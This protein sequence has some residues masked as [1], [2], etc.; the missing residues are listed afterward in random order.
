MFEF[1]FS[2]LVN[3]DPIGAAAHDLFNGHFPRAQD[4][5]TQKRNA[6]GTHHKGG[7]FT[8]FNVERESQNTTKLVTGFG[9]HL[10]IDHTAVALGIESFAEG[11]SG[12]HQDHIS[13]LTDAIEGHPAR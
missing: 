7:Q 6:E 4:A 12:V 9:D 8:R 5:L 11:I 13:H 2:A 1:V 10:A 3:N